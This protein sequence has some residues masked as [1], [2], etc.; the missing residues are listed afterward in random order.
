MKLPQ[1]IAHRGASLLELEN[2][3]AAFRLA[4]DLG[5]KMFEC[6]VQLTQDEVPIIFHD[7]S[8]ARMTKT[9]GL[10][11]D[12][13]FSF[14]QS[15]AFPIPSLNT[16]LDWLESTPMLMNLELKCPPK[17]VIHLL[18]KRPQQLQNRILLS[19]FHLLHLEEARFA[20][21]DM[22]MGLLIHEQN[23]ET[24]GFSGI[25]K[26]FQTLRAFSLHVDVKL[27]SPQNIQ[28]F[29]AITPRLLTFTVNDAKQAEALY[30]QGVMSIFSDDPQLSHK[31]Q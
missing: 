13:S 25:S 4:A 27:L 3:L 26:L 30:K 12:C 7:E 1:V 29:L 9:P 15:L 18:K 2:T 6:D 19:S 23:L 24:L 10:V 31:T 8:L 22:A 20:L 21:P 16:L 11:Q 5:S 17:P 14:I 28:A